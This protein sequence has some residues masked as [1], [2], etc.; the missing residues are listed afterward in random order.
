MVDIQVVNSSDDVLWA[1]NVPVFSAVSTN[2]AFGRDS[3]WGPYVSAIRFQGVTLPIGA[4]ITSAY[5][6]FH[7]NTH[8]GT[9]PTCTLYGEDAANPSAISSRSDGNS[10]TKTTASINI[11][12]PMSGTWWD[13]P[14]I[15]SIITEL[16]SKYSYVSGAAMQFIVIGNGASGSNV[17][18]SK[19]FDSD[20]L[21][22]PVLHIEYT[23]GCPRQAM[24]MRR[25]M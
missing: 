25:L 21:L 18:N 3:S 13:S 14:S 10:R 17:S 6:R 4:T 20:P 23:S 1:A 2:I 15:I 22:A 5:L 9:P 16:L 11:T 12:G 19:A 24:H 7:Y 8:T